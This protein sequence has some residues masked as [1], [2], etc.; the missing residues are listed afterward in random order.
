MIVDTNVLLRALTEDDPLQTPLAKALLMQAREIAAPTLTLCEVVWVLR[1]GYGFSPAEAAAIIRQVA[2]NPRVKVDHA[3][4]EAGLAMLDAGGDF[5]D[6]VIA[7]EG[8]R[9]G[10]RNLRVVRSAGCA[11]FAGRWHVCTTPGLGRLHLQR[12]GPL[13]Q[14]LHAR[15]PQPLGVQMRNEVAEVVD[16]AAG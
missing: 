1:T 13:Q 7:F 8:R 16:V 10:R 6:G 14:P 9:L 15:V 3:V 12:L 2:D 5:A 11:A 4:V